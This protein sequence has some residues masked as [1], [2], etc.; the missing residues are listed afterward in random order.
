MSDVFE[1]IIVVKRSGQ[2][3]NFDGT[4]IAVA[5]KKAFDQVYGDYDIKLMRN[6][7]TERQYK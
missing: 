2:R 6:I 5:I 3:V 1:E 4:K 7:K